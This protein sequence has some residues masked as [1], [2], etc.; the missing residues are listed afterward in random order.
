MRKRRHYQ[1]HTDHIHHM[2]LCA[3]A[4][5]ERARRPRLRPSE[6]RLVRLRRRLARQRQRAAKNT[7]AAAGG[8]KDVESAVRAVEAEL[9]AFEAECARDAAAADGLAIRRDAEEAEQGLPHGMDIAEDALDCN[10]IYCE[11]PEYGGTG[12]SRAEDS[13]ES[14][15]LPPGHQPPPDDAGPAPCGPLAVHGAATGAR[16]TDDDGSK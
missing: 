11:G 7:A 6:R 1:H 12:A 14:V 10:D 13:V 9:A 16:E 2:G 15:P 8:R 3:S 4:P 5:A